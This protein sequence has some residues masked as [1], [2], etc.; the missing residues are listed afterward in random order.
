MTWVQVR[1]R[2][3]S[4]CS[5]LATASLTPFQ[6]AWRASISSRALLCWLICW[7]CMAIV[8]NLISW[9][10]HSSCSLLVASSSDCISVTLVGRLTAQAVR[11][12][13]ASTQGRTSLASKVYCSQCDRSFSTDT[14]C[15]SMLVFIWR[16]VVRRCATSTPSSWQTLVVD[17][18]HEENRSSLD[19]QITFSL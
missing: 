6:R 12:S 3:S 14:L 17:K 7:Q 1:C 11:T 13:A 19:G 18:L 4:L 2:S 16:M 15:S 5:W 10:L 9:F 8:C